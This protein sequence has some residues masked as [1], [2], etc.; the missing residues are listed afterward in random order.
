MIAGH[1]RRPVQEEPEVRRA[2]PVEEQDE[3]D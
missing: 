1:S 3:S 2:E